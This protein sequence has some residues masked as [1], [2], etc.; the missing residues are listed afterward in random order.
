MCASSGKPKIGQDEAREIH[1]RT[2]RL[3]DSQRT[4][5]AHEARAEEEARNKYR[6]KYAQRC[7]KAKDRL[8]RM[9]GPFVYVDDDGSRRDA[10]AEE[11][12]A[13][14]KKT[15]KWIDEHCDF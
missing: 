11:V 15:R 7:E 2:Q 9:N 1:A 13:D 3:L 10:T 4:Q 14:Q 8:K 12:I 6:K 5:A